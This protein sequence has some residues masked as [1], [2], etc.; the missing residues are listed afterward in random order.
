MEDALNKNMEGV[1]LDLGHFMI[2]SGLLTGII[3]A[4]AS[5]SDCEA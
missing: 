4:G 5:G 1:P 2:D 3:A